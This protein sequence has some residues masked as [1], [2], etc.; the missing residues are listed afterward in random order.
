MDCYDEILSL[1]DKIISKYIE[2]LVSPIC[3][4]KRES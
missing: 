3:D 1:S 2:L 4:I